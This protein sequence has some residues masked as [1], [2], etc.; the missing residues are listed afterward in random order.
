MGHIVLN[1]IDIFITFFIVFLQAAALLYAEW[2]VK[3][4]LKKMPKVAQS[5]NVLQVKLNII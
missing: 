2:P 1:E 5:V 4:G 3:M